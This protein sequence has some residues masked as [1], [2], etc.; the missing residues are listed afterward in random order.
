MG[1]SGILFSCCCAFLLATSAASQE[2]A[3]Q[4][5]P[6][7]S[8]SIFRPSVGAY[9]HPQ[10]DPQSL[11]FV[12]E[13]IDVT[14]TAQK[15]G[16]RWTWSPTHDLKTGYY[17]ASL[18]G[19]WRNGNPFRRDWAFWLGEPARLQLTEATPSSGQSLATGS[20]VEVRFSQPVH[21]AQVTFNGQPF[22]QGVTI[23]NSSVRAQVPGNLK[24]GRHLFQISAQAVDGSWLQRSWPFLSGQAPSASA[25]RPTSDAQVSDPVLAWRDPWPGQV[26]SVQPRLHLQFKEKLQNLRVRLD[27]TELQPGARWVEDELFWGPPERALQPGPHQLEIMGLRANGQAY[28]ESWRFYA[29][30]TQESQLAQINQL[31]PPHQ[32]LRESTEVQLSPAS[33]GSSGARPVL[34]FRLPAPQRIERFL[35]V[36]DETVVTSQVKNQGSELR[37]QPP[38]NLKPGRHSALVI[39]VS[40]QQQY[41]YRTW[42]FQVQ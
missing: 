14:G 33:G 23:H 25:P 26:T 42:T 34:S 10:V 3:V 40:A 20:P 19:R 37:F 16:S 1:R 8:L 17:T 15:S 35:F 7:G 18:Q 13:G 30:R 32:I 12:I 31:L 24:A 39:A 27:G 6:T 9:L 5:F 11:Q 36:V 28:Q 4:P 38:Q 41:F 21:R 29:I 22:N 2:V